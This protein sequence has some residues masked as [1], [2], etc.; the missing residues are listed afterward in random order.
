MKKRKG[1]ASRAGVTAGI[2]QEQ[3]TGSPLSIVK[4]R[5]NQSN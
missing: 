5:I 3:P 4:D 2:Q 1:L